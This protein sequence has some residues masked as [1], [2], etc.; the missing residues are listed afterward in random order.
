MTN[1]ATESNITKKFAVEDIIV[2]KN[3]K[4]NPSQVDIA[5]VKV[6]EDIDVSIYTP[7]CLAEAG[8]D[9]RAHG[10]VTL[11]GSDFLLRSSR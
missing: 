10:T 7:I 2:H 6:T 5:L 4:G 8:F 9:V 1:N 11:T 3:K